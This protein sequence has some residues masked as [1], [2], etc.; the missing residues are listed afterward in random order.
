MISERKYFEV[1]ERAGWACE[2]PDCGRMHML[3]VHHAYYRSHMPKKEMDKKW[4]LV[5]LCWRCHQ[6]DEGVHNGNVEL[7]KFCEKLAD[8]RKALIH[9]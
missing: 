3:G 6:G 4:N 1:M 2:N 7:R 5:V 9:K 8:K